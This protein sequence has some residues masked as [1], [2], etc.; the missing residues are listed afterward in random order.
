MVADLEPDLQPLL[1]HVLHFSELPTA[2]GES[3]FDAMISFRIG[4]LHISA[5]LSPVG[6]NILNIDR[7]SHHLDV[8]QGELG[9]LG[10]NVAVNRNHGAPV[11]V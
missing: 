11:V 1:K 4:G 5:A 3:N 8:V 9:T 7:R 6:S 10:N 2:K